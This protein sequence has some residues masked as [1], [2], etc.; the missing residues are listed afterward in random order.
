MRIEWKWSIFNPVR[1]LALLIESGG[2][3]SRKGKTIPAKVNITHTLLLGASYKQNTIEIE[4]FSSL[5]EE[6]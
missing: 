6:I 4:F 3:I 1:T 5:A 2:E